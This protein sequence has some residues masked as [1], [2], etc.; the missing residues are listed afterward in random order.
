MLIEDSIV[1]ANVDKNERCL[2]D[3]VVE[4][5]KRRFVFSTFTKELK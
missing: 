1:T 3:R 4:E 2:K 5:F